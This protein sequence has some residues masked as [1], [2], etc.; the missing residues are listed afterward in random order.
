[1]SSNRQRDIDRFYEL[2]D[3]VVLKFP[4]QSLRD[5]ASIKLPE[6]GVYFFFE[7][8]ETR[9]NQISDRIVR[10]GTH[11]AIAHSKATLYNR[12]Y[13]HK[14]SLDLT[15]NHRS[16]VFRKLVGYSILN[17]DK[18][19]FQYWGDKSK[20]SNIKIIQSESHLEKYVSTYLQSMTFTVLEVPGPSS[21]SNDRALIEE[22]T[23][24]LLSNYNKTPIDKC[25]ANWLG[26]YSNDGKVISSGLWNNKHVDQ[27]YIDE[28]Y[29]SIFEEHLSKMNNY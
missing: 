24:A 6:K 9:Y 3:G 14:G 7:S 26:L 10:I 18:L 16:S 21:K 13:N 25:S 27:K 23:I 29:F 15:G 5:L 4:R 8:G 1:M 28:R 17:R 2:I 20:K 22:N 12:L 19:H 11:A